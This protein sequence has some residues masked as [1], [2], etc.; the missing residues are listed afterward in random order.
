MAK[1]SKK[2]QTAWAEMGQ[3]CLAGRIRVLSRAVSSIF[4]GA[5][6][7]HG[8][9]VPQMNILVTVAAIGEP[10]PGE[11]QE[12]RATTGTPARRLIPRSRPMHRRIFPRVRAKFR[13]PCLHAGA[14]DFFHAREIF[15]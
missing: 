10:R 2:S 15:F 14:T 6:R 13:I 3:H 5:M 12:P 7:H 8:F 11:R 9:T 4:D 1:P